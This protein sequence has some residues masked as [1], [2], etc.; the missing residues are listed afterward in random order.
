MKKSEAY[1]SL[2]N[3]AKNTYR[4]EGRE[5]SDEE[6]ERESLRT[7]VD[8]ETVQGRRSEH[9]HAHSSV[10]L[11]RLVVESCDDTNVRIRR[12][13]NTVIYVVI[14]LY[15]YYLYENIN[16]KCSRFDL[17]PPFADLCLHS[18]SSSFRRL[19]AA[20]AFSQKNR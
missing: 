12:H 2:E 16:T 11:V 19:C 1:E 3:M 9:A 10:Y 4:S 15:T 17:L 8:M 5:Y 14:L 7:M 6:L 18:S 20:G 13:I